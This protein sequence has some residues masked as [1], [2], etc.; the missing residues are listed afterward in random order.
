M[1]CPKCQSDNRQGLKFCEECGAE[2]CI[3]CPS[4]NANIPAGKN[5]CG[6][7]GYKFISGKQTSD[8]FSETEVQP[9][10]ATAVKPSRDV[11]PATGERKHVTVLFSDLTGYTIMSE[12]LD[13]EEVKEITTQIFDEISKIVRKYDGFV[14]KFAGDAV[15]ALFG[16]TIAHEDDPVRAIL[17]AREIHSAVESF[18]PQYEKKI[19]QP[20][21]MH[22]GINTG[23]VVTG[24]VNLAKGTHG[25]AGDTINVATRLSNLGGPGEILVGQDTYYRTSGYFVFED[26][27][28][29]KIRGRTEPVRIYK[30]LAQ[31][32]QPTKTHGL[33]GVRANLIGR[34]A[35]MTQLVEAFKKL[36]EGKRSVFLTCGD[37]GTGKS[38]LIDEFKATLDL[39]STQW[40]EGHAY[41]YAQNVPYF[42]LIDLLKRTLQIQEND[43]PAQVKK[44]IETGIEFLNLNKKDIEPYIGSLFSL[45]YPELNDIN[46]EFWKLKLQKS[47]EI[48][49]A[50]LSER[51]PTV[52]CLED[53][54]WADSSSLDLIRIIVSEFQSPMLFLCVYRPRIS[55]LNRHHINAM[56]TS[57]NEINLQD[58]SPLEAQNMVEALL[59]T[60][61]VPADLR[62]FIHEKVG[63]NPFYLEELI[64]SL[65][66]SKT[67][68]PQNVNWIIA[69]PIE[70]SHISSTIHGII[71]SRVD[72][73][74]KVTKRILQEASVIGRAFYYDILERITDLPDQTDRSL[75]TLER[76]DL[77]K[78]KSIQPDLEY[79]FKHALTQ[80]VVYNGLLIKDRRELHER[81]GLVIEQLFGNRISEFYETLAHHFIFGQSI[82]KAV[83][84]LVKSGEKSSGKYALEES[85]RYFKHAFD[86]MS[87]ESSKT[88]EEQRKF[89]NL[90]NNWAP[91]FN[92]RGD[93]SGLFEILKAHEDLANSQDENESVGMFYAWLGWAMQRREKLRDSY[94][95]L[96]KSL[97][98]G[99]K[100]ENSKIIG[101]SCAWLTHTCSDLGF[102]DEA[103]V[104]GKRA[105]KIS[106]LFKSDV[107]LYRFTMAGMA[108][109]YYFRGDSKKA[110]EVG[111]V[112]LDYGQTHSDIRSLT[113]GHRCVGWGYHVGGDF[114]S[115]IESFKMSIQ[116]S[117]DPLLSYISRLMLGYS[118]LSN[119]QLPEAEKTLE[120]TI[121]F[122]EAFGFQQIQTSAEGLLGII[123]VSKGDLS[124]GLSILEEN[125]DKFLKNESRYRYTGYVFLI[126]KIYLN[127]V[128]KAGPINLSVLARN[129][130]FLVK[131][132][133]FAKKKA[134]RYFTDAIKLS[135]EIGAKGFLGQALLNLGFLH[136]ATKRSDS[137]KKYMQ[138]AIE[139]FEQCEAEIYVKQ[140]KEALASL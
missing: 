68:V 137:A 24:E 58:L 19:G 95:Y 83:F 96:K 23:L 55:L 113:I 22:T 29:V 75:K 9:F 15:M 53:L 111:K 121:R 132:I 72:R 131:N 106:N 130:G 102:F 105:E 30:V 129:I 46:P 93:F 125:L 101:Y 21:S 10:S 135:Q 118:Y 3:E 97:K 14:E 81:I 60:D 7:C 1:K 87:S 65:I 34:K 90:L 6:T 91:V 38:R 62:R 17:A 116:V 138:E 20:L 115:A 2:L 119:S 42:P 41:G 71:S 12:K 63:G 40:L 51:A 64:N 85:H 88:K 123:L 122:G 25:V 45:S 92:Y 80:E 48:I 8:K 109:V 133:P 73:L 107:D 37:A 124:K 69:R 26:Q 140:A 117:M 66:E 77:I 57:Y 108:L 82:N 36:K 99:E 78:T 74:E 28:H 59:E 31:K 76:L 49:L 120:E 61:S 52:I 139:V 98:I 56:G 4:C 47:I 127:I 89:L 67:I 11:V 136:Q 44:K 50:A 54:H 16:A 134:E 126:G 5:F 112:L 94:N 33:W 103:I 128:L 114:P 70:A 86:L 32:D 104:Y 39:D 100:I 110:I 18:N 43:D 13:P 79:I 84:Y 35:E 27:K